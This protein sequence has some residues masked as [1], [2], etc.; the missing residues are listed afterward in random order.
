MSKYV[1]IV[2]QNDT[3]S[4]KHWHD[5]V[6][7]CFDTMEAAESYVKENKGNALQFLD[8]SSGKWEIRQRPTLDVPDWFWENTNF[9]YVA[10]H[11]NGTAHAYKYEPCKSKDGW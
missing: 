1:C 8:L 4:S 6:H 9:N 10:M 3:V 11:P 2:W 5:V 7:K